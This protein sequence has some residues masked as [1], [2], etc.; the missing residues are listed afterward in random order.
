MRQ[1][2]QILRLLA[3][4][5]FLMAGARPLSAGETSSASLRL[6][7]KNGTAE[8]VLGDFVVSELPAGAQ[9]RS[10]E[11][12]PKTG[13][14]VTWEGISLSWL[15]DHAIERLSVEEKAAIDLVI[16]I[17]KNGERAIIPRGIV[18]RDPLILALR[19]AGKE[20]GE[21]GP[22]Y[23]VVP[24]STSNK[25][26]QEPLPLER[27]FVPSIERVELTNSKLFYEPF[28]LSKRSDPRAVR[29]ERLF[30]Q[31]CMACH[32]SGRRKKDF[33]LTL[34]TAATHKPVTGLPKFTALDS[35][36]LKA[37]FKTYL[38]EV[39]GASAQK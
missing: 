12:D 2:A 30:V 31:T 22:I 35:A 7:W 33:P 20:V 18:V 6:T 15:L 8:R 32:D 10:K 14:L 37:Y 1:M 3:I 21:R 28:F 36:A 39:G 11:K 13:E 24:W 29:G 38:S 23:S 9:R 26:G 19:R 34:E 5:S 16:L 27:Y 17:G 4:G 25:L